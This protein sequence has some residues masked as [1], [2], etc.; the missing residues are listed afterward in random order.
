M[1][2]EQPVEME[3]EGTEAVEEYDE[4]RDLRKT[5]DA[6]TASLQETGDQAAAIKGYRGVLDYE[7][8]DPAGPP[9]TV[10]KVKEEAIYGLAKAYADSRRL[11]HWRH[12]H[13]LLRLFRC[14]VCRSSVY[15]GVASG[16]VSRSH[17]FAAWDMLD[18]LIDHHRRGGEQYSY[19]RT[20]EGRMEG[21]PHGAA[22]A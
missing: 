13:L 4:G 21:L 12:L 9:D 20:N 10:G 18:V 8:V 7:S 22:I 11:V 3:V 6:V 16:F 1:W 15:L 19:N 14:T 5:L 17:L 2:Q